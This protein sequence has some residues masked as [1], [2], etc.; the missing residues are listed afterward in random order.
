MAA[1]RCLICKNQ[2][3]RLFVDESLNK[4]LTNSGIAASIADNFS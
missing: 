2:P 3:L 4:G 1:V